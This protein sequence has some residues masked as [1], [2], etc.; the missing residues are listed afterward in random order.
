ME[1]GDRSLKPP[2]KIRRGAAV[3]Y[4]SSHVAAPT[5]PGPPMHEV[6]L[7]QD[8]LDLALE[9]AGLQGGARIERLALRLGPLAGV[10]P[11]ALAFAFDVVTRG[12][13]AEG[14]TLEIEAT[15]IVAFCP[16]CQHTLETSDLLPVCPACGS[17]QVEILRGSELELAWIEV[18]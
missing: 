5:D 14:A 7:M 12:T 10:V 13:R 6:S 8:A 3:N 4:K 18:T 11:E 15:T 9:Q 16:T 17:A 1:A 2:W